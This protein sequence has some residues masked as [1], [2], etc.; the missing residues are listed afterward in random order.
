[1]TMR[2]RRIEDY[3][4]EEVRTLFLELYCGPRSSLSNPHLSVGGGG[5]GKGY[6]T[7]RN[8]FYIVEDW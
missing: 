1:M 5:K 2:N 7:S 8:S 3:R 4:W 6:G